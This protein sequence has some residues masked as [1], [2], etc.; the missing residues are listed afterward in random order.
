[1]LL[2]PAEF[3]GS[4]RRYYAWR[5]P[6]L[7][8]PVRRIVAETEQPGR[9]IATYPAPPPPG[10]GEQ[11]PGRRV[12]VV[13]AAQGAWVQQATLSPVGGLVAFTEMG[14]FGGGHLEARVVVAD[15]R[16]GGRV[17]S[18]VLESPFPPFYYYWLPCGTRLLFLR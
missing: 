11:Q 7:Q 8:C 6:L 16:S 1:M 14:D 13:E 5:W 17:T 9:Q 3:G 10:G 18:L 15:A 12:C 2:L 4:Y